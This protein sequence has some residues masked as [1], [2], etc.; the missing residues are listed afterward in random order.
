[1]SK[2]VQAVN[3]M[4]IHADLITGVIQGQD[5]GEL[6]FLYK[7]KHKWS[8]RVDHSG[9]YYLWYYPGDAE[10]ADLAA[11]DDPDWGHTPI[12]TY[13]TSDIGTKE[14]QASF[15]ELYGILKER[16]YG[17]NEVLDDIISDT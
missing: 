6:F 8:I 17:M 1:M 2:V 13:K 11:Y 10:L 3:A 7:G 12:V 15:A 16:I 14:A 4:I 5:R 9:E